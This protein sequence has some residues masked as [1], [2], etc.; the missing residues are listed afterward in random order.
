MKSLQHFAVMLLVI[1]FLAGNP[2]CT[3]SLKQ[4]KIVH[5]NAGRTLLIAGD[6]SEFKDSVRTAVIDNY[7]SSTNIDII[8]I[9]QL[10]KTRADRY[11]AVLIMETCLAWSN[12]N[13]SV[14]AFLDKLPVHNVVFF[15]TVD[16]ED[17]TFTYNGV[18]AI[19][20]ASEKANR[21]PMIRRLTAEIDAILAR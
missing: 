19:T 7:R 10:A 5:P 6:T 13:P 1:V 11:D 8:G 16:D 15:M 3:R 2:A 12:F 4:Q 18:D 9:Q 21:E 17:W 14:K 20:S